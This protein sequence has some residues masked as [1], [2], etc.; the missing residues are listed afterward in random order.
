MRICSLTRSRSQTALGIRRWE[1]DLTAKDNGDVAELKSFIIKT[2]SKVRGV[3][4]DPT[5]EV[6]VMD[7]GDPDANMVKVRVLWWSRASRQHQMLS[8]YDGVLTAIRQTL[9]RSTV[10][11]D[12]AA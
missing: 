6:L 5:L 8:S 3:L 7:L 1:Y 10:R 9:N 11:R 4:S 2:V 12:H